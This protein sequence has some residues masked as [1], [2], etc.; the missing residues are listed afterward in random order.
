MLP[1]FHLY[2]LYMV[3]LFL[4]DGFEEIEALGTL[5]ILRRCGLVVATLSVTGKRVVTGAHGMVI[6]ADSLFRK[7]HLIHSEA[8]VLPGG[9]PGARTLA[10]NTV[11]RHALQQH[12]Y[13]GEVI[14]AIC[15]APM[16]LAAA[17]LLHDRHATIYPGMEEQ[18]G[19]AIYH[20]NAYVVEDGNL[21][22]AAGPGAT[23]HF[24]L[25]IARRL[26]SARVV[27]DVE[28][29]MLYNKLSDTF[30]PVLKF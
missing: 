24:A 6:K 26:C 30:V 1:L 15:A 9:L 10:T 12:A 11:L 5:D 19:D 23:F 7:N 18:L 21:I 17:G 2:I 13:Q 20:S 22:T 4:A 14:A 25:A 28:D 29:S 16:A 27:N 3:Y 8:L